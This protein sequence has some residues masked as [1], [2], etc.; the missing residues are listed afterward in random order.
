[1]QVCSKCLTLNSMSQTYC[2]ICSA[3]LSRPDRVLRHQAKTRKS[4]RLRT[5]PSKIYSG[6]AKLG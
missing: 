6:L 4:G 1:M 5:Q 3:L 2:Q